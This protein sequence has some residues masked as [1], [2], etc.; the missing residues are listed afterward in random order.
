MA[1]NEEDILAAFAGIVEELL[2]IPADKV[3]LE[4]SLVDDLEVDSLSMM[5]I[6]LSAQE[7]FGV[8]IPDDELKRL[9]TVRD[10]VSF[11]QRTAVRT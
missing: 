9:R 2:D 10:V 3:T 5:E 11:V 8:E 4:S 1:M 7:K 6:V